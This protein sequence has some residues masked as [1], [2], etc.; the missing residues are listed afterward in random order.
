MNLLFSTLCSFIFAC[1][2]SLFLLLKAHDHTISQ[3]HVSYDGSALCSASNDTLLKI[4]T[5]GHP[6]TD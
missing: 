5:A 2:S 1:S 4:W 6:R 3:I